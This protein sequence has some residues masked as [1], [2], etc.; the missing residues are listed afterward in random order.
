M[1]GEEDRSNGEGKEKEIWIRISNGD[2]KEMWIWEWKSL[3][4]RGK[5]GR[6]DIFV[7]F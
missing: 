5:E 6:N 4:E 3:G 2:I 1:R 7:Y